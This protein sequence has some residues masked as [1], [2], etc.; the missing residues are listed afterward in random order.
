MSFFKVTWITLN[1]SLGG[2]HGS[3]GKDEWVLRVFSIV[4]LDNFASLFVFQEQSL[5]IS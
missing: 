2:S 5:L 1:L 4:F 3:R